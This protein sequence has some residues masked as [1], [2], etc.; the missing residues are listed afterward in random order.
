[1]VNLLRSDVLMMGSDLLFVF[2]FSLASLFIARKVA[3]KVGLVDK[4]NYRKL[5]NGF[6]P[7]VGGISVFSG[8]AFFFIQHWSHLSQP[9]LYLFCAGILLVVGILD[10]RFDVSV[11]IRAC[12]QAAIA[13]IMMS[14][15]G[16]HLNSLGN[17][18]GSWE[19]TLGPLGYVLTLLAVLAAINAFNMVDGIDGL[20]GGLSCVTFG[21][22]GILFLLDN[23]GSLA[24]WCFAI[25]AATLPYILLNLGIPWGR[26]FKVFMG[27]A[28]ST[29]IGF[30]V[31]WLLLQST[32]GQNHPLNPVTAL[33]VIAIPLMDMITITYR[34]IKKGHS[35]F[36][37]DRQHIHHMVMRAG[38]S[39]GQAFLVITGVAAL[40]AGFGIFGEWMRWPEWVMLLAFLLTFVV[41]GYCISRAWVAT[42]FVRR[43]R[44]RLTVWLGRHF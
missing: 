12:V 35:P 25:I 11:K 39:S 6:I 14:I 13:I 42:R 21:S 26:K 29:V 10:D 33:W 28:G 30:T 44:R 32:Q 8:M 19:L 22:L 37:P 31:V 24:L 5:H 38:F 20:L 3:R 17:I 7:L 27:D 2:L 23:Q 15:G 36:S 9:G 16:L 4:P 1:M 34:R 41:Y 18:L 40:L 43:V